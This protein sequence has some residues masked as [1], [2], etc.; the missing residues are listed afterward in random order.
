MPGG[1]KETRWAVAVEL[2]L[3]GCRHQRRAPLRRAFASMSGAERVRQGPDALRNSP[4]QAAKGG[5]GYGNGK[6]AG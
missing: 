1:R 2:D 4:G 5:N 3:G 6:E